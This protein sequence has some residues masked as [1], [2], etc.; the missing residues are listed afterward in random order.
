MNPRMPSLHDVQRA[1]RRSLLQRDDGEAATYLVGDAS[2][3]VER[4]GV[5]RN[6]FASSLATALR[7]SFP[8][9]GRLVGAEFFDGAA[10]IFAHERPPR[11]ANL[12]DYGA[13]FPNFLA[14]FPPAASLA[15]MGD[16]ARLEWAVNR[17]L[18]A[19]DEEPL[20]VGRLADIPQTD[21]DRVRFMPHP[22]V[23]LLKAD[24]PVDTIWRAVLGEDDSALAA[25]DPSA[26]PVWLMVQ[27]FAAGVDVVRVDELAWRFTAAL[28]AGHPLGS[29]LDAASGIDA[30]ALLADHLRAGRFIAFSL[31]DA[32]AISQIQEGLQ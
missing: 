29:A 23:S 21:H 28:C 30:P 9:V 18:H 8:A 14:R 32:A 6:T 3:A 2:M 19:P 1:L 7:L 11:S 22:S 20:D 24:F 4:L 15:Y 25:I 17:A 16:V 10:R 27:R 13:E 31:T 26:G 5:Y 12:D